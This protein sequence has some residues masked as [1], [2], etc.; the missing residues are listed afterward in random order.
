MTAVRLHSPAV[1][2]LLPHVA[3]GNFAQTV[4]QQSKAGDSCPGLSYALQPK[5][6]SYDL[7]PECGRAEFRRLPGSGR[8]PGFGGDIQPRGDLLEWS[9]G[10]LFGV[11]NIRQDSENSCRVLAAEILPDLLMIVRLSV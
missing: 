11:F 9:R 4:D 1:L 2:Q 3:V 6:R 5:S 7:E 10:S 8:F